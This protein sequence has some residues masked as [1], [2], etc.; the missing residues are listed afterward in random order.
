MSKSLGYAIY[1]KD[2]EKTI[3]EKVM[4]ATTDPSKIKKDDPAD[5]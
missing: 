1:L 5:P 3:Y 4:K 2:D